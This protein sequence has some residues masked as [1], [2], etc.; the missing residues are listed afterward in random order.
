MFFKADGR[1]TAKIEEAQSFAGFGDAL[2]FC[3]QHHLKDTE[4]VF[5]S[6]RPEDDLRIK[7]DD[8]KGS[9]QVVKWWVGQT[10]KA[11]D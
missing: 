2:E 7:I 6:G 10:P 11:E 8:S 4:L 3:R 9:G 5:R 1:Q